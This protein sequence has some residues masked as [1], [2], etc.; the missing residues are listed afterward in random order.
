MGDESEDAV[1]ATAVATVE[2]VWVLGDEGPCPVDRAAVTRAVVVVLKEVLKEVMAA[3]GA[4]AAVGATVHRRG[5]CSRRQPDSRKPR[6]W[7]AIYR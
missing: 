3:V 1:V 2:E 6:S 5:R 7:L 4:A